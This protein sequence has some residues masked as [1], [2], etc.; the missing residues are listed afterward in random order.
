MNMRKANSVTHSTANCDQ[1]TIKAYDTAALLNVHLGFEAWG[2]DGYKLHYPAVDTFDQI[3]WQIRDIH[4]RQVDL[5][6]LHCGVR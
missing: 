5:A 6:L 2:S 3:Q 1:F 4:C